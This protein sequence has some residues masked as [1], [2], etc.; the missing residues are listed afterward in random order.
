LTNP[1][2]AMANKPP[3]PRQ[4]LNFYPN[5]VCVKP[6]AAKC[7]APRLC[8]PKLHAALTGGRI[9]PTMAHAKNPFRYFEVIRLVVMMYVR[10]YVRYPLSLRDREATPVRKLPA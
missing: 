6:S 7:G 4:R 2:T 5:W 3:Y 10:M 8:Q 1:V 9:A